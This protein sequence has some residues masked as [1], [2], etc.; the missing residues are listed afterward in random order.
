VHKEDERPPL[1]GESADM[2]DAAGIRGGQVT[3]GEPTNSR[4][5]EGL[6]TG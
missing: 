4:D 1:G 3:A 5:M 6:V 2:R